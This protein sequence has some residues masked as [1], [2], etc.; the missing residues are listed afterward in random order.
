MR[1]RPGRDTGID[2]DRLVLSSPGRAPAPPPT[3]PSVRVRRQTPT[4]LS[5]RVGGAVAPFRLVLG[6]S[7]NKGWTARVRG[8]PSLGRP[9]LVDGYA[10]GWIVRPR[11]GHVLDIEVRWTPQRRVWAALALS[12]AGLV[13]CLVLAL[14]GSRRRRDGAAS[15]R[16]SGDDTGES[17]G[18]NGASDEAPNNGELPAEG[19]RT[20]PDSDPES[21]TPELKEELLPQKA[22][23]VYIDCDLYASTSCALNFARQ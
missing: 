14:F 2:L 16:Q 7:W 13:L 23:V 1:T 20:G 12:A 6:E 22:A 10:N 3:V 18:E 8:G 17:T 21:L 11:R 4:S 9:Q 5:L 15:W 19:E